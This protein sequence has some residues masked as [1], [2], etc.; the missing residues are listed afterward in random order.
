[1]VCLIKDNVS[2]VSNLVKRVSRGGKTG[3]AFNSDDSVTVIVPYN[4]VGVP[5]PGVNL[6]QWF[7]TEK[8][9]TCLIKDG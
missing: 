8:L 6:V 9:P 5:K 3:F 2:G 1:M 7:S 4:S